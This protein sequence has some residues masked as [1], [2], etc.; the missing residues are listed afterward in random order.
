ME[1]GPQQGFDPAR[2]QFRQRNL[3]RALVFEHRMGG[4]QEDARIFGIGPDMLGRRD[5]TGEPFDTLPFLR[6]Q[7]VATPV[8]GGRGDDALHQRNRLGRAAVDMARD[9]LQRCFRQAGFDL[10]LK[11][12]D[13]RDAPGEPKK[14]GNLAGLDKGSVYENLQLIAQILSFETDDTRAEYHNV[15]GPQARPAAASMPA[16]KRGHKSAGRSWPMPSMRSI[17]A[18]GI[19]AARS[20]PAA[21][22]TSGSCLP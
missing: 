2:A 9:G 20:I 16:T 18:P 13:R 12:L 5:D 7:P 17:C 8:E 11:F 10:T 6:L 3:D 15:D 14:M 21:T 4:G 19:F 1:H 22:G